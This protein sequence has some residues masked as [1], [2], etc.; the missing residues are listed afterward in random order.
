MWM[1][2]ILPILY[3]TIRTILQYSKGERKPPNETTLM[4]EK[5]KGLL[6]NQNFQALS[7]GRGRENSIKE[8]KSS[9]F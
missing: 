5:K 6:W 7:V 8:G 4:V 9:L 3:K 2:K 1:V